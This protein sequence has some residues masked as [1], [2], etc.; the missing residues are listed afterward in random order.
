MDDRL[1]NIFDRTIPHSSFLDQRSILSCMHQSYQL[2]CE[3]LF[4]WLSESDYL[5][6][7]LKILEQEFYS[8]KK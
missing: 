1:K 6:D 5:T 4:K 3:D 2:G 8:R 7:D